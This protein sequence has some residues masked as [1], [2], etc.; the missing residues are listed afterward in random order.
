VCVSITIKSGHEFERE[1]GGMGED[2]G[3]KKVELIT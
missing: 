2:G 3:R 1:L